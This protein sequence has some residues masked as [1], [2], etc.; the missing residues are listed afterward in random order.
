M[1]LKHI[2]LLSA[3]FLFSCGSKNEIP[4]GILK[5][6][7]MQTVLWDVLRA[8]AFTFNFITKDSSKKTEVENVKLQQQIFAVHK[9]S[10]DEFYK[11]YE[12][13]KTHPELMQTILDSMINKA[14]R[15]KFINTKGKQ[16]RDTL[17]TE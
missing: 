17:K 13:Y 4:K 2:V 5:P 8:D 16:F 9:T 3:L 7:Q 15:D 11:S 1:T 10:R 14:T 6:A 12:F